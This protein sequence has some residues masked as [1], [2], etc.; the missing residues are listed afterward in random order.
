M[1]EDKDLVSERR[2]VL[3]KFRRMIDQGKDNEAN[4]VLSAFLDKFPGERKSIL[5]AANLIIMDRTCP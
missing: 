2:D 4:G 1:A 3:Q 5:N